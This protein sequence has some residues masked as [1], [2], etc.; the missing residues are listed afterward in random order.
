MPVFFSLYYFVFF[1]IFSRLNIT[2]NLILDLW[3]DN[4]IEI[5]D[6]H[7]GLHFGV[8]GNRKMADKLKSV[9]RKNLPHLAPDD[10]PSG[11]PNLS[12]H[13]PH[14]RY[15]IVYMICMCIQINM[16]LMI[17]IYVAIFL[18]MNIYLIYR[19]T[20]LIAVTLSFM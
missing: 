16:F 13:Y 8:V 20:I 17:K 18:Y 12:I 4:A 10:L 2:T 5:E 9:I 6:L 1:K 7:D 14:C 15:S 11:Q 3:I 19:Y